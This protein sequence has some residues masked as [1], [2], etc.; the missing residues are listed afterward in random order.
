MKKI[1]A[2]QIIFIPLLYIV[3][4]LLWDLLPTDKLP[5]TLEVVVSDLLGPLFLMAIV[6]WLFICIFWKIPLLGKLSQFLFGTKPNIQGTWRGYLNYEWDG[7]KKEKQVFLTIRQTDGYSLNIWLLTDER[8]SS[9]IF[10]DIVLIGGI[11]CVIYTYSNEESPVNKGKNP[12][13]E[14]FCQLGIVEVSSTLQGIYYTTRK[15]FG[16]LSFEKKKRKIGMTYK[17]ALKL[18]GMQSQ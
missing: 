6:L 5:E 9:S 16:E 4:K 11:Q 10:A 7:Q 3:I 15:T 1:L 2:R 14:G 17:D 12:S 18:F 8:T 13:H